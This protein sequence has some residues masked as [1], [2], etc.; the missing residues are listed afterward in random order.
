MN[1]NPIEFTIFR[2][3]FNHTEFRLI[4]N[5]P[6]FCLVKIN[7]KIVNLIQFR[8]LQQE[9]EVDFSACKIARYRIQIVSEMCYLTR[10]TDRFFV[11]KIQMDPNGCLFESKINRKM[12]NTIRFWIDLIR[13]WKDFSV[14]KILA[15]WHRT[16]L[17]VF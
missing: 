3:I 8:L 12:V 9:S 2:L 16:E 15:S 11:A 4:L 5:H 17:K 6:Q 1:R 7:R 14:C 10:K 13:F